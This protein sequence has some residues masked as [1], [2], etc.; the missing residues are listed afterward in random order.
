MCLCLYLLIGLNLK[1]KKHLKKKKQQAGKILYTSK[2]EGQMVHFVL[3][4]KSVH[5][6]VF[7]I[8][9]NVTNRCNVTDVCHTLQ[10]RRFGEI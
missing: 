4:I 10:V 9:A 3:C 6:D 5:V 8:W 1:Y 7:H 2:G